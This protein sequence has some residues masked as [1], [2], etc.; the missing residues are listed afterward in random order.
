M[1]SAVA[2][3]VLSGVEVLSPVASGVEI[4]VAVVRGVLVTLGVLVGRGVGVVCAEIAAGTN[5]TTTNE[6]SSG[7]IH[8]LLTIIPNPYCAN[9][10]TAA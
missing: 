4:A 8:F 5:S 7:S 6:N 1:A 2:S 10:Q 9:G 3:A